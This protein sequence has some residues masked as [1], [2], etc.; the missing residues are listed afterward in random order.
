MPNLYEE[1]RDVVVRHVRGLRPSDLQQASPK[2]RR[3]SHHLRPL[4]SQYGRFQ[5]YHKSD[6]AIIRLIEKDIKEII[7]Q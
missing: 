2:A 1:R 6:K 3:E 5:N 4:S 7:E